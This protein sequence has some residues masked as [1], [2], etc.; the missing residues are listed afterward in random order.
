MLKLWRKGFVY[1]FEGSVGEYSLLTQGCFLIQELD[2]IIFYQKSDK[3][4]IQIRTRHMSKYNTIKVVQI[5]KVT[6][7]FLRYLSMSLNEL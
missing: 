4:S 2:C 3:L 1:V 7:I 5:Y 6:D